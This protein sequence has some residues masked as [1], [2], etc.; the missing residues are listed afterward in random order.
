MRTKKEIQKYARV[1]PLYH[2][3]CA[4]VAPMVAPSMN[5]V[6]EFTI[7][8]INNTRGG[9]VIFFSELNKRECGDWGANSSP[10]CR[11]KR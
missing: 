11:T 3:L 7:E 6:D 4:L 5:T 1:S 8:I 2:L 10:G 9:I